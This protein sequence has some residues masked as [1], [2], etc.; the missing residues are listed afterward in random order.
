MPEAQNA[1]SE[2]LKDGQTVDGQQPA[3][4]PAKNPDHTAS[5]KMVEVEIGGVKAN[6]PES[7]VREYQQM[8]QGL[9]ALKSE[10]DALKKPTPKSTNEPNPDDP[11]SNIE[12]ELFADPSKAVAKIIEVATTNAVNKMTA[13]VG[14]Q[15]AQKEFWTEFYAKNPDLDRDT[16]G[17][18]VTAVMNREYEAISGLKVPEAIKVLG[19][20]S[21]AALMKIAQKRGANSSDNGKPLAEGGN[22]PLKKLSKVESDN[23][24]PHSTGLSGVIRA[25][26]QARRAAAKV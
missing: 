13:A 23:V 5:V 17:D 26:Q 22:E 18:V 9:F 15:T 20:K 12:T 21:K 11:L 1:A 7:F 25:R 19:E 8:Q 24:S 4:E 6:V 2:V 16:D 3:N 10:V 14:A